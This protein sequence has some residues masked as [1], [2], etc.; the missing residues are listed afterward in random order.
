MVDFRLLYKVSNENTECSKML[1]CFNTEDAESINSE[2]FLFIMR[3]RNLPIFTF[4]AIEKKSFEN[5]TSVDY[6]KSLA[7]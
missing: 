5:H 1:M 7:C 2:K 6:R 3:V 4:Q